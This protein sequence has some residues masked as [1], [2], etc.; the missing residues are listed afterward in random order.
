MLASLAVAYALIGHDPIR[1]GGPPRATGSTPARACETAQASAERTARARAVAHIRTQLPVTVTE[2]VEVRGRLV[3]GTLTGRIVERPRFRSPD[4]HAA[5]RCRARACASG[6]TVQAARGRALTIAYRIALRAARIEAAA[7]ARRDARALVAQMTPTE[8]AKARELLTPERSAPPWWSG[9]DWRAPPGRREGTRNKLDLENS[10]KGPPVF[11]HH[12]RQ[13]EVQ[14][15]GRDLTCKP[16]PAASLCAGRP[17][18]PAV[19]APVP[20]LEP[21]PVLLE[22]LPPPPD[23]HLSCPCC[24]ICRRSR[25]PCCWRRC[26]RHGCC[27]AAVS[28]A[29]AAG[30]AGPATRAATGAL[31]AAGSAAPGCPAACAVRRAPAAVAGVRTSTT[32]AGGSGPCLRDDGSHAGWGRRRS[33]GCGHRRSSM[34]LVRGSRCVHRAQPFW[35]GLAGHDRPNHCRADASAA[36]WFTPAARADGTGLELGGL[37][38]TRPRAQRTTR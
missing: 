33:R 22:L 9:R 4:G 10:R 11:G 16:P 28:A 23:R 8:V 15:L 1:L 32:A 21:L 34:G 5:C 6:D 27:R 13:P 7:A 18:T 3:V 26:T 36:P 19:V 17:G 35:L 37:V 14:A 38:A 31:A 20:L 24:W 30:A 25:R 12:I 29:R 2:R